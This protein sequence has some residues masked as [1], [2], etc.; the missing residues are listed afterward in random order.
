MMTSKKSGVALALQSSVL[1]SLVATH[2]RPAA[3]TW[4]YCQAPVSKEGSGSA[5]LSTWMLQYYGGE[6]KH[7][8]HHISSMPKLGI[9]EERPKY[10]ELIRAAVEAA[11]VTE[12]LA[13]SVLQGSA[14]AAVT[15]VRLHGGA[16]HADR[17]KRLSDPENE[18]ALATQIEGLASDKGIAQKFLESIGVA[19]PDGRLAKTFGG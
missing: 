11:S 2:F 9:A 18:A 3:K 13:N 15:G 5:A 8:C 14:L 1:D 6:V 19:T 16:F 12:V 10:G 17:V 7:A 4:H